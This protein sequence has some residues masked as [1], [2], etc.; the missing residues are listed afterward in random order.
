MDN[1]DLTREFI[2]E[3]R[4][5]LAQVEADLVALEKNPQDREILSRIFRAVHT[6]KGASG[7][8]GLKKLEALTH[9]GENLLSRL[10]DGR[11]AVSQEI[12]TLL[13]NLVDTLQQ[14]MT[15]I[16]AQ[17]NDAALQH[18]P[19]AL[20][21]NR[22][23][24]SQPAPAAAPE[25][26]AAPQATLPAPASPAPAEP[27]AA[28]VTAIPATPAPAPVCESSNNANMANKEC[29][30][31]ATATPAVSATSS[32]AESHVRVDV[33][34]LDRLMNLVGELV[35]AR[36]QILQLSDHAENTQL[37][38]VAQRLNLVT[39]E[40]QEEVMKTRL[41]PIQNA[42]SKL[43]RV[44]RDTAM[45]LGRQVQLELIGQDTE[46]DR[47]IIEAIKDPMLHLVRNALDHG[48]ELPS[49]RKAAGKPEMGRLVL[50]AFHEGGQV[51]IE[52][53][54][55]GRGIQAA[56]VKAKALEKGLITAE[57]AHRMTDREAFHLLFLPGFSTAEKVTN[58]SGRGVGMDVV[59]TNIE[60]L[61]G[62][63]DVES[64]PGQGTTVKIKIPLTLAIIPALLVTCGTERYAVPQVN[65][66]ELVRVEADQRR[67]QIEEIMGAPVCRLR[68]RLLPLVY[69]SRVFQ[70]PPAAE[71]N[72][73]VNIVVLQADQQQFGLVVDCI[74]D[75]CE[76]VVKPLGK[77]LKRIP[78]FAGATVL[79][80]GTVALILDVLGLAQHAH[81]LR[82][83]QE[84]EHRRVE[85]AA[86]A[87]RA[88]AQARQLLLCALGQQRLAIDL[89]TVGRLEKIA[90]TQ[91]EHAG[92]RE[93]VQY[94]G[95]LMDL[96]RLS[97]FLGYADPEEGDL[98]VVVYTCQDRPVG[99]VVGTIMDILEQAVELDRHEARTGIQGRCVIQG[100]TTELV[101]VPGVVQ[102]AGLMTAAV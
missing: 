89:A 74:N 20:K 100:R 96:V 30:Q 102:A 65:L 40:L 18:A 69:L 59:K 99:L 22:L 33:G 16:E 6:I 80:D 90:R 19:L 70:V 13:L 58:V 1:V 92:G 3:G 66:V 79:G 26:P 39:T 27:A 81:V 95:R 50:R 9:A 47:A 23:L 42:W 62:S 46:L 14:A 51:N 82:Q 54:D 25:T 77:H 7:F 94:R 55:D 37:N 8:L 15:L 72:G 67:R 75:T 34:L 64:T 31:T 35:L 36:N 44:V 2:A 49:E 45:A 73:A 93:V 17:G 21:I 97:Q 83:A 56:K 101:D 53:S 43:P 48:I 78:V 38:T 85:A 24:Q 29:E 63:V 86:A 98:N 76:I 57:Q 5:H 91:V 10:R 61:G 4:E 11:M 60:K 68:G 84:H 87:G 41:Q 71:D 88:G 12:T 32:M 52:V 28:A